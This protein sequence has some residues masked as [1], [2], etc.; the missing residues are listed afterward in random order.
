MII[1]VLR[2][3]IIIL[4]LSIGA[5]RCGI[6]VLRLSVIR[7][8]LL[9]ILPVIRHALLLLSIGILSGIIGSDI[10]LVL[11]RALLI[12]R[13]IVAVDSKIFVHNY[14]RKIV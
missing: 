1:S 13:L 11:S 6:I 14:L 5:L 8:V 4:R 2:C 10:L 12:Y 7:V 3:R 9:L